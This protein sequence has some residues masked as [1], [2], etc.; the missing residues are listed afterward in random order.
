MCTFDETR[1]SPTLFARKAIASANSFGRRPHG[2]RP[3]SF[4][5]RQGAVCRF[6]A[7][8]VSRFVGIERPLHCGRL[9]LYS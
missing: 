9:R 8:S 7:D 6:P 5:G 1:S 3:S 2:R 4:S